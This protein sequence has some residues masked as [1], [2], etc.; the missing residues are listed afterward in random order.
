M[1][2]LQWPAF[3]LLGIGTLGLLLNEFVLGWGTDA[4]LLLAALNLVGLVV[5]AAA[6]RGERLV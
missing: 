3:G 1:R 5:V 6:F 2:N 4:T